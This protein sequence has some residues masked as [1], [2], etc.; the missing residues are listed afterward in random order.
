MLFAGYCALKLAYILP[1]LAIIEDIKHVLG[2]EQVLLGNTNEL[3]V[4]SWHESELFPLEWQ[5][6]N[7]LFSSSSGADS[8][9][10]HSWPSL[11]TTNTEVSQIIDGIPSKEPIPSGYQQPTQC[12]ENGCIESAPLRMSRFIARTLT[13]TH[14]RGPRSRE[15]ETSTDTMSVSDATINPEGG[16]QIE[17]GETSADLPRLLA[18][19]PALQEWLDNTCEP[20]LARER[21]AHAPLLEDYPEYAAFGAYCKSQATSNFLLASS[22]GTRHNSLPALTIATS[23]TD[24]SIASSVGVRISEDQQRLLEFADEDVLLAPLVPPLQTQRILECPFNVVYCCLMTFAN[25]EDWVNHSLTHFCT[26]DRAIEPPTYNVCCFCDNTFH[27]SKPYQSWAHY[28]RHVCLHHYLGHHLAYARPNFVLFKYLFNNSLIS[29]GDYRELMG[30]GYGHAERA[31]PDFI[32]PTNPDETALEI[33]KPVL[34]E[35][36]STREGPRPSPFD[37]VPRAEITDLAGLDTRDGADMH[38]LSEAAERPQEI[39]T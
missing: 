26:K 36:V 6:E 39:A 35:F 12:H 31:M 18:Q 25:E 7:D 29:D 5:L 2:A 33:E 21:A 22:D 32:P 24:T 23:K 28:M 11:P 38:R 3:I 30:N 37:P 10:G 19:R 27:F 4:H 9:G 15:Q 14:P 8:N 16:S 34:A 20:P 1:I 17:E 13:S